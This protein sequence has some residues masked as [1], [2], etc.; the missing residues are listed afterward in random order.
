MAAEPQR[1]AAC[2]AVP[3]AIPMP[4]W[5]AACRRTVQQQVVI[6]QEASAPQAVPTPAGPQRAAVPQAAADLQ[7]APQTARAMPLPAVLQ[8]Q[9]VP[10]RAAKV[11]NVKATPRPAAAV[12]HAPAQNMYA[13]KAHPLHVLLQLA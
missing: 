2:R 4:E 7:Q 1:V 11:A 9:A 5:V 3:A 12:L 6:L 10:A 8:A 13:H